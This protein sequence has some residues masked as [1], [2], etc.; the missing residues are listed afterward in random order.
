[1]TIIPT[2]DKVVLALKG[3]PMLL[4]M[5]IVNLAVLAMVTYLTVQ[6]AQL[7]ASERS[8]LVQALRTCLLHQ[9]G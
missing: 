6:A 5:L 9:K 8:E 3:A 2:A 7:R 4:A 1:V